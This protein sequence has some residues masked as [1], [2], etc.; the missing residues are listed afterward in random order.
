MRLLW[1][2]KRVELELHLT[3]KPTQSLVRSRNSTEILNQNPCSTSQSTTTK[4]R[5]KYPEMAM[6]GA[7]KNAILAHIRVPVSQFSISVAGSN[8]LQTFPNLINRAFSSHDDH[9]TKDQVTDRVLSV[10]KDFPKV[11]PSKVHSLSFAFSEIRFSSTGF[12]D[13]VPIKCVCVCFFYFEIGIVGY[14]MNVI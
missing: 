14:C 13:F 9:L 8:K 4:E 5:E 11:D 6:M 1:D 10:I 3:H 12:V 7:L 2:I